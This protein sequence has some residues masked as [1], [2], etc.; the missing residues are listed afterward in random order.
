MGKKPLLF[1]SFVG[2]RYLKS[3]RSGIFLSKITLISIAGV[4][5]GVW[6][7]IVVLSVMGGFED[8]LRD[9][10][11]GSNAHG[12]VLKLMGTFP[13]YR[14]IHK[15]IREKAPEVE[16]A[17]PF[18][19]R[20]VMITSDSNVTGAILKGIDLV[21]SPKV[22][23]LK[24][25]LDDALCYPEC[26]KPGRPRQESAALELMADP[27]L[28]LEKTRKK[29]FF[30]QLNEK[31]E[32]AAGATFGQ[33][34]AGGSLDTAPAKGPLADMKR[35]VEQELLKLREDLDAAKKAAAEPAP[36]QAPP[37]PQEVAQPSENPGEKDGLD[38]VPAFKRRKE[39]LWKK[40]LPGI[41]V[42]YEMA[43]VLSVFAGDVVTVVDPLG[44]GI[45]PTGPVP[46][47]QSFRVA[48]LFY[49]G[50]FEYDLKFAYATM[51]E[52]QKLADTDDVATAIE[53]TVAPRH[54]DESHLVAGRIEALLGHFPYEVRDWKSMNSN[55][56]A[57][58]KMERL[59][60]FIILTFITMVAAFNI[61][62]TLIM[63]V[64]EKSKEI[65]II[66]SMGASN[67]SVMKIFMF[68]GTI[69]G[70]LGTAIGMALGTATC[71]VVDRIGIPLDQQVYYMPTLPVKLD[72]QTFLVVPLSALFICFVATIY[73]AYKAAV[74]PPVDGLRND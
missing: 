23:R 65:A 74:M 18:L 33:Q 7:M 40:P 71:L 5:V 59:A 69:I 1:E 10:I 72:L 58:L 30:E 32:P 4:A 42:G 44:G 68:N 17:A 43:K 29:S 35:E 63:M 49:S 31:K 54:L 47:R 16:H 52:V 9:K 50:M 64:L 37:A 2:L 12:N 41:L 66:K 6:A 36:P 21:T 20:E 56:F 13:E 39:M 15:L 38:Y 8:D 25:Q 67:R 60:M 24:K 22:I 19:M 27:D 57:A 70:M 61:A 28:L 53:Y 45:G 34:A 62:S 51:P 55:L 46:S 14:D 11:I 48:G 73:P 26:G 3:R